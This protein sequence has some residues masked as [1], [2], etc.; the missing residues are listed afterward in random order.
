MERTFKALWDHSVTGL[1]LV[2]PDG[3]FLRVNHALCAILGY[4]ESELQE[5][6]FQEVT[7]SADVA[8]DVEMARRVREGEVEWYDMVKQYVGKN[9]VV[10]ANLRVAA[11]RD[12]QGRFVAYISQIAPVDAPPTEELRERKR[13]SSKAFFRWTWIKDYW[14]QILMAIGA[15]ALVIAE[16]IRDLRK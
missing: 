15:V 6:T 10:L 14:S 7:H 13:A 5:R 3:R 2:A 4:T 16:I 8:H 9:S 11:V 12:E 1:A